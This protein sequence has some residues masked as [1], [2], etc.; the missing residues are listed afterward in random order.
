MNVVMKVWIWKFADNYP[1]NVLLWELDNPSNTH[2]LNKFQE[3]AKS[4]Q[5]YNNFRLLR[6]AR[7]C[8]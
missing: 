5:W 7:D 4:V 8:V 6:L 2:A 1:D 3:N